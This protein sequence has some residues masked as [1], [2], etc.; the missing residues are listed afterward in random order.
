MRSTITPT[1]KQHAAWDKLNDKTTEFIVFGGAAGGGKSWLGCEWL[2]TSCFFYPGTKYFIGRDELKSI[3]ESTLPTW[4][5]V[6]Q[7]HKINPD[8]LFKYNGQDYCFMFHNGS[9]IDFKELKYYPSDPLYERFGSLEY[10]SGWIEEAGE[11]QNAAYEMISSRTG[12]WYNDRFNLLGKTLLTCNPKKNFLYYDFYRPHKDHKLP[13]NK[14]FIQALVDD[15]DKG[16]SGYKAKL[17]NLKGAAR[18]RLR[19]GNWEYEDD[20]ANLIVYDSMLDCFTNQHVNGEMM[21]LTIDV[22]R[23]GQ[24][25][26]VFGVWKGMRVKLIKKHGWS[27]TQVAEYARELQVKHSITNSKTIAD[28]DGVGGGVVDILKCKGFVNNSRP[29]PNPVKPEKD[30]KGNPIPENYENLKSQCSFRMADRI[31]KGGIFIEE[32]EDKQIIIEEMEQVKDKDPGGQ[33][34]KGVVSKDDIKEKLGRSPDYWD[35][36]MMREFFELKPIINAGAKM[37]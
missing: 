3:R 34:K 24:D 16:E 17:D 25:N 37:L 4:Y 8:S 18:E 27:T 21:C 1:L 36:I 31:N 23:F 30:K 5:K 7:Y 6:L 20:P 35:T 32:T 9:R 28:E 10:T 14:A 19:F 12:R 2:L 29:Y 22:A 11:I 33:G 13:E 15:N 26:T